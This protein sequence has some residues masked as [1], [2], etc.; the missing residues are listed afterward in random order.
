MAERWT[1]HG[2]LRLLQVMSEAF[3]EQQEANKESWGLVLVMPQ[4]VLEAYL[5][6][7][8]AAH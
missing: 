6:I 1:T 2:F 5:K 8:A 3:E 4:E 7:A